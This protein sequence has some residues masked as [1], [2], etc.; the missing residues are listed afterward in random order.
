MCD[1][2]SICICI[3]IFIRYLLFFF[4]CFSLFYGI[5][6]VLV[7]SKG[8]FSQWSFF[9]L[10]FMIFFLLLCI[11]NSSSIDD[12]KVFISSALVSP[13]SLDSPTTQR[14]THQST[15]LGPRR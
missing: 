7:S 15:N 3:C 6:V 9:Y 12:I 4:F 8:S 1:F 13:Q 5:V 10:Y 11:L 14:W 2:F